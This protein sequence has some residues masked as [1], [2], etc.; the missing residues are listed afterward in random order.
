MPCGGEVQTN[1]AP[2]WRRYKEEKYKIKGK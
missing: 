1:I 2:I